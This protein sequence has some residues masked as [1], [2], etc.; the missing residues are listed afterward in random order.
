[1]HID[2]MQW[3]SK[4]FLSKWNKF[5]E[6]NGFPWEYVDHHISNQFGKCERKK[7]SFNQ[8]SLQLKLCLAC[9]IIYVAVVFFWLLDA[10]SNADYHNCNGSIIGKRNSF[11]C[12][13]FHW[14]KIRKKRII[15]LMRKILF[16]LAFFLFENFALCLSDGSKKMD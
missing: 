11:V 7:F 12:K 2:T 1:M 6:L 4:E 8:I 5:G 14:V 16:V 10:D 3:I 13:N 15:S 9:R